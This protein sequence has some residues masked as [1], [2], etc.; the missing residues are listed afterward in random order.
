[1]EVQVCNYNP[2]DDGEDTIFSFV[3][4]HHFPIVGFSNDSGK[5]QVVGTC[6]LLKI[7]ER[8]FLITA[9]HVMNERHNVRD[10][11]LWLWNYSDGSKITITEDIIC[12]PNLDVPHFSDVAVVEIDIKT[13][14]S[15]NKKEFHEFC[16]LNLN[17]VLKELDYPILEDEPFAYLI[18]GYSSSQNKIIQSRY[19]KPKI[20]QYLTH[21]LPY[22]ESNSPLSIL[23]LRGVWDSENISEPGRIL[24]KPQGMSGGGMWIV[25]TKS[26]FSPI[27]AGVSVAYLKEEKAVLAVKA[28][29]ILSMIKCFFPDVSLSEDDLP[30]KF[31][32]ESEI[33]GS[34]LLLIPEQDD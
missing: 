6:T 27:F 29:Y 31:F 22:I 19:K 21:P 15:F 25:S 33:D 2:S 26:E 32:M 24:P 3:S 4:R 16:F 23:T 12:N 30:I 34:L 18:A 20:F 11:E 7:D 1:M 10:N 5:E 17:R 28:T 13:Y 8:I 9:A 14:P